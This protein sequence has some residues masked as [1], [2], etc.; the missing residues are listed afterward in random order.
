MSLIKIALQ[1]RL[2]LVQ[3]LRFALL[4]N[5]AL[6]DIALQRRLLKKQVQNL[7]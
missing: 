5:V 1:H 6:T 4:L 2:T 3:K 7:I